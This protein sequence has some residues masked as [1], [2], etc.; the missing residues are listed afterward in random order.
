L[1]FR[2]LRLTTLAV[3][4]E[5][6]ERAF[7]AHFQSQVDAGLFA[8]GDTTIEQLRVVAQEQV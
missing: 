2:F 1:G 8:P 7:S 6:R 5:N 3:S 4:P